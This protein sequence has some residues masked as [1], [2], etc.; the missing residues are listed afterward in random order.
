MTCS[1]FVGS[2]LLA[3][4]AHE[5]F[6]QFL[7][8]LEDAGELGGDQNRAQTPAHSSCSSILLSGK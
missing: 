2:S 4:E 3:R 6:A 8:R 7:V 5:A 1:E